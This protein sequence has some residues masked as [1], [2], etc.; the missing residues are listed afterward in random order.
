MDANLNR[1]E[2]KKI[3]NLWADAISDGKNVD[4]KVEPIYEGDS[5]RPSFFDISYSINGEE[6]V[7]SLINE[8]SIS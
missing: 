6:R 4:V 5:R 7:T 3:E 1:G 8:R 2:Y